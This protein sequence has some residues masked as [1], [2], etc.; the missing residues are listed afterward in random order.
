MV[1]PTTIV[2]KSP[3]PQQLP[4][5]AKAMREALMHYATARASFASAIRD[6]AVKGEKAALD[7]LKSG[8][9]IQLLTKPL[10]EGEGMLRD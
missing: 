9:I 7:M 5:C 8:D 10:I 4:A 6:A 2:P 3:A 1:H